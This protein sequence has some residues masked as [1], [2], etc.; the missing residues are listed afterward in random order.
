[1]VSGT[2]SRRGVNKARNSQSV[3]CGT[4]HHSPP[5]ESEK[6]RAIIKQEFMKGFSALPF[7]ISADIKYLS[8]KFRIEKNIKPKA[9]F[10]PYRILILSSA[11]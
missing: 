1:M 11:S 7:S 4:Y 6:E 10:A 5:A 3:D 2:R 8:N 9:G